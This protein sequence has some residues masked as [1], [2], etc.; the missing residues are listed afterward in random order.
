ME[1]VCIL[2][3]SSFSPPCSYRPSRLV[4]WLSLRLP[5]LLPWFPSPSALTLPVL[6]VAMVVV[7]MILPTTALGNLYDE[8]ATGGE[9]APSGAVVMVASS[10]EATA[11]AVSDPLLASTADK[12][13]F[14]FQFTNHVYCCAILTLLLSIHRGKRYNEH[15]TPSLPSLSYLAVSPAGKQFGCSMSVRV[16]QG[17]DE[18]SESEKS[19]KRE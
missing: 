4:L 3:L 16:V 5:P 18:S 19:E 9:T 10:L 14:A 17:L 2:D 11:V 13:S 12:V 15:F 8:Q 7:V 1:Q 6:L